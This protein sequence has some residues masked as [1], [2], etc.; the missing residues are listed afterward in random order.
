MRDDDPAKQA[1]NGDSSNML[2]TGPIACNNEY[3]MGLEALYIHGPFSFQAEYGW[4][5]LDGAVGV[6]ATPTLLEVRDASE[7]RVQRRLRPSG[8]YPDRRE[9]RLRQARRHSGQGVL[10]Q[11]WSDQ[12][13]LPRPG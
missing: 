2:S 9:P 3:L 6:T 10:R 11:E 7:L 1:T 8:V 4:N 13:I 5:F 12:Q